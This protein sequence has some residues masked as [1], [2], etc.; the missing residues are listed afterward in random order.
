MKRTLTL[1]LILSLAGCGVATTQ[2]DQGKNNQASSESTEN[3]DKI[4]QESK[5]PQYIVAIV[6]K[7]GKVVSTRGT[8]EEAI[9]GTA[10]EMAAYETAKAAEGA[11][12]VLKSDDSAVD[13][14]TESCFSWNAGYAYGYRPYAYGYGYSYPSYGY[15]YPSYGYAY[16]YYPSYNYYGYGYRYSPVSNYYYGGNN[17]YRWG[18]GYGYRRW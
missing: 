7:D 8:N 6:D 18:R 13:S 15:S 9:K 16:N 12:T 3:L 4:L 2:K 10:A 17:Y 5:A 14:S 11:I 1:A